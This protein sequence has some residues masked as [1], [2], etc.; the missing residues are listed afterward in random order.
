MKIDTAKLSIEYVAQ[1]GNKWV[2]LGATLDDTDDPI[3]SL[4]RLKETIENWAKK[5]PATQQAPPIEIP[6]INKAEERLGILIENAS[7]KEE[8]MAYKDN[9]TTPYLADLFS[10]KHQQLLIKK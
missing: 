10:S 5:E 4:D 9:L 7:T 6:V 8:L 3:K 1:F 2:T